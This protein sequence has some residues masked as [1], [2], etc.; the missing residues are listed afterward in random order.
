MKE[1]KVTENG[2]ELIAEV[3]DLG[4]QPIGRYGFK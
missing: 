4:K 3:I 1:V 2:A